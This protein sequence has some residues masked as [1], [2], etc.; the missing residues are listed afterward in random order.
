MFAPLVRS[1]VYSDMV[2]PINNRRRNLMTG[3][4]FSKIAYLLFF[5]ILAAGFAGCGKE[6]R[7][8]PETTGKVGE[9]SSGQTLKESPQE[10]FL[11]PGFSLP[12]LKGATI[13]LSEHRGKVV[14]LNLWATWC[15]PCRKE[16]P[17][18]ERLYQMRKG[19]DF[20]I[21]AVSLDRTSSSRVKEF[22]A[23][24]RMSFPVLVDPQGQVGRMYWARAIPS[25]FLLDKKGVI[26]WVVKGSREWDD[27]VA[28]SKIDELLAE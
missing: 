1:E 22:V 11:A 4:L 12:D 3:R 28:L 20:E 17:S 21:L 9:P 16:I 26:R 19:E 7:S 18:L 6:E 25:S 10:G 24:Y 8:N 2:N 5:F 13:S 23:N 14:L 15:G 27:A